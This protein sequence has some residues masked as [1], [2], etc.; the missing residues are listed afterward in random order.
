MDGVAATRAI[1]ELGPPFDTLPIVALTADAMAGQREQYLAAGM[2]DYLTKPIDEDA[3]VK[4]LQRWG[5]RAD[6]AA[7]AAVLTTTSAL[8]SLRGALPEKR[9]RAIMRAYVEDATARQRRVVQL[10]EQ[11]DLGRLENE[12][13]D[14]AST[15][16]TVGALQL[17]RV[18]RRLQS[19]CRSGD[20]AQSRTLAAAIPAMVAAVTAALGTE[21]VLAAE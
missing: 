2:D 20:V 14:L 1:R 13:H 10:A 4:A 9:I 16:E 7:A 11:G 12:A 19:A 8:A 3:L 18:A 6:P 17:A 21:Y 15:S 5:M